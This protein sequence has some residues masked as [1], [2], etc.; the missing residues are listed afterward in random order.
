MKKSNKFE[1]KE[2]FSPFSLIIFVSLF[3]YAF[4]LIFL[5]GWAALSS[6][7]D[8][9]DFMLHPL[10]FPKE[11]FLSNFTKAFTDLQV[12]IKGNIN[13]KLP[14]MFLWTIVYAV[15]VSIVAQF[16]RCVSAY[17][18]A[19][20]SKYR[21]TKILYNIVIVVMILPI[22]G[23]SAASMAVHRTLGTYD[24]MLGFIIVSAGFTGQYFLIYYAAFK[25]VSWSYAEAAFIDGANHYK[26]FFTIM[27]PMVKNIMGALFL[28]EFI[29]LWNDYLTVVMY[30]PS[31]PNVS[32]GL[33]IFSG[34]ENSSETTIN[35]AASMLVA[36]PIVVLYIVFNKK[37]LGN[38]SV[39]GLKG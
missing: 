14:E 29:G 12:T 17:I 27:L 22:V 35:L 16:T 23:N 31:Y 19:K 28:L 10:E 30:L 13:V 21:F 7:R 4:S 37:L 20:F 39:G 18:C 38:V 11:V 3:V 32:Y 15:G 26:V 25:G 1:R 36:L 6:V 24:N 9:I 2:K 8:K 34:V 33:Y 5:L